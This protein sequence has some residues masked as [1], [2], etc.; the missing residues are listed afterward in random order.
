MKIQG[1]AVARFVR[2]RPPRTRAVLLYGPDTGLVRERGQALMASVVPDV[3]DP[4][5]VA[6]LAGAQIADEPARLVDEA[7]ALSLTGGARVVRVREAT[8]GAADAFALLL[9]APAGALVV[10]EAGDLAPRSKLRKLFEEAPNAAAIGCYSDEG[11]TLEAVI[12][13]TLAA[14]GLEAAP[15]AL[16]YLAERLGA[17]RLATRSEIDKLA[18]YAHGQKTV[19]LADA[20]ASVGDGASLAIEDIADCAATGDERGLARALDHAF[21]EGVSAIAVLRVVGRHLQRIQLVAAQVDAGE[22]AEAVLRGLRPPLFFKRADRFRA[23]LR[24]WS[25]QS[26]ADALDALTRAEI[27]CKSTGLPAETVCAQALMTLAN[28]P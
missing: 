28:R 11:E 14:A 25:P 27:D 15:D 2:D 20:A 13:S 23:A 6:E 16:A 22:A 24:K 7:A 19:T 17:D 26:L 4:F 18:L 12:R 9:A 10:V 1:A 21:R 8:D 3:R 5:R